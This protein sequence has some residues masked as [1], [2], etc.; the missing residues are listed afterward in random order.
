MSGT[1]KP[2][3]RRNID[4]HPLLEQEALDE[5]GLGLMACAGDADERPLGVLRLDLARTRVA[6]GDRLVDAGRPA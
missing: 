3:V 4:G 2:R 1:S 6:L 5:L